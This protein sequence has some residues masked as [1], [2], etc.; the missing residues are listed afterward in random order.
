M[1]MAKVDSKVEGLAYL[2]EK[3]KLL[4]NSSCHDEWC[5][6]NSKLTQEMPAFSLA[7][8]QVHSIRYRLQ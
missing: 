7:C 4:S 6:I 3:N 2:Q 8:K 5:A 1:T